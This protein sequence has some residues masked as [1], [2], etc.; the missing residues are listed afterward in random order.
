MLADQS[1]PL[2]H[3][4]SANTRIDLLEG[5]KGLVSSLD[6]GVDILRLVVWCGGPNFVVA[7]VWKECQMDICI[8]D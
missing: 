7:R 4:L 6:G 1:V 3:A 8:R 2:E 5:L